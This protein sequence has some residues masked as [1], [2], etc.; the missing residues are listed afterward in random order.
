MITTGDP[1]IYYVEN[2][3]GLSERAALVTAVRANDKY[4]LIV[5]NPNGFSFVNRVSPVDKPVRGYFTR[6]E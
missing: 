4:D 5:F 6:K 3:D 1:V 2:K